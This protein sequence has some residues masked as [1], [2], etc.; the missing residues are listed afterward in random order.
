MKK[1]ASI[2]ASCVMEIPNRK[3]HAV[4]CAAANGFSY[5]RKVKLKDVNKKRKKMKTF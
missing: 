2:Q 3:D 5:E 4:N 1:Y